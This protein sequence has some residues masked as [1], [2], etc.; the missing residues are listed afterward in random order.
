MIWFQF[1]QDR[2]CHRCCSSANRCWLGARELFG[3]YFATGIVERTDESAD[4][5]G[6]RVFNFG[7]GHLLPELAQGLLVLFRDRQ[8]EI[9]ERL[10]VELARRPQLDDLFA[11]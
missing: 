11:V 1:G 9:A 5:I 4:A 8:Q 6:G 7:V 2:M 3:L 10:A